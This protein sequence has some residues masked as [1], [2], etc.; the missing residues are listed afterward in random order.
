MNPTLY[1]LHDTPFPVYSFGPHISPLRDLVLNF[2]LKGHV[3]PIWKLIQTHKHTLESILKKH[4]CLVPLPSS[5]SRVALF[6]Y[7]PTL[8]LTQL[9]QKQYPISLYARAL[10]MKKGFAQIKKSL[11]PYEKR[12]RLEKWISTGSHYSN[13]KKQN[14]LLIDDVY[15]TGLTLDTARA[16]LLKGDARSVSTLVLAHTQAKENH[17][18]PI[19]P[20]AMS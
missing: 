1:K 8:I 2:K 10:S 15:N 7:Y 5:I 17:G 14:I 12:S 4:T 18:A 16:L 19:S 11:S 9:I 20:F 3:Q 13:I 6:G